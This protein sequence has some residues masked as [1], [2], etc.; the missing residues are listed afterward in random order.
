MTTERSQNFGLRCGEVH[1]V[2]C[3]VEIRAISREEVTIRMRDHGAMVH[4][5]TPSWYHPAR[6]ASMSACAD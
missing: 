6:V 1:P 4:G 3:N 5:F 2:R